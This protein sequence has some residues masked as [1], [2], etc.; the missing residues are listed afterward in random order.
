MPTIDA[1]TPTRAPALPGS[2]VLGGLLRCTK[3]MAAVEFGYIVPIMFTMFAGAIEFSQAITVDRRVTQVAASTADIIARQKTVTTAQLDTYM[4]M[5]TEI[6]APFDDN[7]LKLTVLNVYATTANP[8][9]TK[10]CWSYNRNDNGVTRAVNT[11]TDGSAYTMPTGVVDG[12][13][14]VVVVEA[15]Y[16]YQPL[17]FSYFITSMKAMNE[18]F[19]LKPR[20]SAG[21]GKDGAASCV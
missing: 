12:G 18:K 9:A 6:M 5:I 8:T 16:E 2:G 20:L 19:Y 15:R 21:I 1:T 10:V 4:Q 7:L 17:V 14:S 13:S 11:Y 3:G